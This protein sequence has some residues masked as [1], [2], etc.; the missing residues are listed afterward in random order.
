MNLILCLRIPW[1][2]YLLKLKELYLLRDYNIDLLKTTVMIIV[3]N[4][5]T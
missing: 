1:K 5:T 2:R 4:I 3:M